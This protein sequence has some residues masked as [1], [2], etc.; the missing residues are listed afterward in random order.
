M[1]GKDLG[2]RLDPFVETFQKRDGESVSQIPILGL[3]EDRVAGQLLFHR[4]SVQI[5]V[6][7]YLVSFVDTAVGGEIEGVDEARHRHVLVLR[8]GCVFLCFISSGDEAV[9][10]VLVS[11]L[12]T[13]VILRIVFRSLGRGNLGIVGTSGIGLGHLHVLLVYL[14]AGILSLFHGFLLSVALVLFFL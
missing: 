2:P 13:S 9:G 12:D 5:I 8:P 7:W 1:G 10:R 6:G 3:V 11:Y 4:V 14:H